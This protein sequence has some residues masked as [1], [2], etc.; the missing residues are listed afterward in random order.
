MATAPSTSTVGDLDAGTG[1][2]I[3]ARNM[4]RVFIVA[5]VVFLA[6]G[7]TNLLG[8]RVG[9]ASASS[10]GYDLTVRYGRVTRPALST[11]WEV[12]I[13]SADG[14]DGPVTVRTTADYFGLFDE[15]G[16]NPDPSKSTA[17]PVWIIWEF[18]PPDGKTLA[19]SYDARIGPDVQRGRDATTAVLVDGVVVVQ[20]HYR[21]TVL[22]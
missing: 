12:R 9:R 22:P 18:D 5:L 10:G 8:V 19:I 6:A 14:F 11:P 15:N 21:T 4:R 13:H 16:L 1:P 17:T 20:V 3:R 7:A 2:L